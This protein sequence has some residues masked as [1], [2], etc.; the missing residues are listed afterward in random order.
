MGDTIKKIGIRNDAGQYTY[1]E[2]GVDADKVD[3]DN[4]T[5]DQKIST[6]ETNITNHT[7]ILENKVDKVSG[8]G[9]STNDYTTTEKTKLS[10]IAAGAEVNQNAFANVVVG[11]T[12]IAADAKSDSLTLVAGSNVTITPD[13]TND[14]ITIAATD[15]KYSAATTSVAGLMSTTDKSKLD[16]IAVEANKTIVDTA[17][18]STSTNPVQNKVINTALNGKLAATGTAVK[19]IA[20]EDGNE[21]ATTYTKRAAFESLSTHVSTHLTPIDNLQTQAPGRGVLDARQGFELWRMIEKKIIFATSVP[22]SIPEGQIV[23]ILE[24]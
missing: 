23:M 22:S 2:I 13:A 6:I 24:S 21:I 11:S 3:I 17:L 18:S 14:K 10:G 12:T 9:L 16:G 7:T 1:T 8:K 20:D 5:L 19:A 15:T 4:T